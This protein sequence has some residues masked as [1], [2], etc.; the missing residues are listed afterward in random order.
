MG[1]SD[2]SESEVSM[3]TVRI[4]RVDSLPLILTWLLK[5]H[6]HTIIDGIWRPHGRWQG[7]NYGQLALLFVA[8]I[9]HQRSH[10]LMSMEG[11][12]NDHQT[13]IEQVTGWTI[14]ETEATDD[15]LGLLLD[16]LGNEEQKGV[17]LQQRLGQHLIQ[18]YELPTEVGRYDTSSFNVHHAAP[19]QGEPPRELL[20]FGHS[21]DNQPGLLQFK[22]GLGTLD[23]AGVPILT[24]TLSGEVADDGLYLPAWWQMRATLGRNDFLFVSDCKAAAMETR[25]GIATHQGFYLFPLPM[26]GE[27]PAWLQEQIS[28]AATQEIVLPEVVERSGQPK[29]LG[30]GFVVVRTMNYTRADQRSFTW[31]EQWFVTRSH[32]LTARQQASLQRRL[33]RTEEELQRLRPRKEETLDAFS[34]RV[35]QVLNKRHMAGFLQVRV[36]ETVTTRKRYLKPG[37]PGPNSPFTLETRSHFS[38]MVERDEDALATARRLAGWRI[39]VSNAS[40]Q[41]MNLIESVRYYRDEWLVEHGFHRFKKGSLP[42]LPLYLHLPDRIRGLML[43]LLITLQALTLIDFVAQRSLAAENTSI[44]GLVPGN[45][46]MKTSHPSAERLLAAFDKLHLLITETNDSVSGFLL[47]PLSPLQHFILDILQV[48]SSVYDLNFNLLPT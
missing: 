37:R 47:E 29:V 2:K 4:E 1:S 8:Y 25:V 39:H 46:K 9:I 18:A 13:V 15:R 36:N 24:H 34:H 11:W 44:A 43:L 19:E 32:S 3:P 14:G 35:H 7:L 40:S 48:P 6:I 45:P 33:E 16:E 22:Q 28:Q 20:R 41:Q 26:T 27:T 21:K 31:E 30:E 10:R 12:L 38:L 42:A 5:M 23:P 17:I